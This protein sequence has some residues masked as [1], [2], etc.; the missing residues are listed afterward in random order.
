MVVKKSERSDKVTIEAAL[1]SEGLPIHANLGPAAT[2]RHYS[3]SL[4][5]HIR[6][7]KWTFASIVTIFLARCQLSFYIVVINITEA[8]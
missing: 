2:D 1:R 5:E 7:G 4:S 8:K 3:G 6:L